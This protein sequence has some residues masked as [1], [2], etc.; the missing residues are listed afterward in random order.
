MIL[1]LHSFTPQLASDPDQQ[2]PWEVGVLYNEDD[3][4]A[5]PAI[6]AHKA[7]G[8]IV[9]DQ[10]PYSGRLIN[11]TM[12]RHARAHGIPS[13]GLE[14]GQDLVASTAGEG[15]LFERER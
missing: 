9:G 7:E 5:G 3:R 14:S 13:V 1:S 10:Q 15:G 2:R 6:A 4:L 11:A 8:M 12:N